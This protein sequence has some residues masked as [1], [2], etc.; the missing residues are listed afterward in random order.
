MH[1]G[2]CS[3][4]GRRVTAAALGRPAAADRRSAHLPRRAEKGRLLRFRAIAAVLLMILAPVALPADDGSVAVADPVDRGA[5]FFEAT[6]QYLSFLA[7]DL[8]GAAVI[9]NSDQV[10]Q[11]P[12]VEPGLGFGVGFG[13]R[14]RSGLWAI[15]YLASGHDARLRDRESTAFARLV[16]INSRIFLARGPGW[17]PFLH[18][19]LGFH[20]LKARD[21]VADRENRLHD[22][23]YAGLAVN[24]GAGLYAP[25]SSRMFFSAGLV[26]RFIGYLYAFG[27]VKG[28][29]VT[30]LFDDVTGPRHPRFLRAPVT[31]LELSLGYEL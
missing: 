29:D 14:F 16:Q 10:F 17:R 18:A 25:L 23:T 1:R 22:A 9:G 3:A 2:P 7:G 15:T 19:G 27:P 21:G 6:G 5:F 13:R 11:V 4:A 12:K 30:D 24:A 20:W 31:A 26:Y 28:I 8:D